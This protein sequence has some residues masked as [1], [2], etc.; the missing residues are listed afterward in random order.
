MGARSPPV[1]D[2][3]CGAS[4]NESLE[5]SDERH[6]SVAGTSV[7]LKGLSTV[8]YN[9]PSWQDP[10]PVRSDNTGQ[11][12]VALISGK[13]FSVK[14]AGLMVEDEARLDHS[15]PPLP[16]ATD[17]ALSGRIMATSG[18]SRTR[19]CGWKRRAFDAVFRVQ[20]G[21][22]RGRRTT[23]KK[24]LDARDGSG[25]LEDGGTEIP[26]QS[27]E[28]HRCAEGTKVIL[29]GLTAMQLQRSG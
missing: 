24:L 23:Y 11:D 12:S 21:K 28:T 29:K 14:L 18:I 16:R 8:Q 1:T 7:I 9:G 22:S 17:D 15:T 4:C 6:L 26:T 2:T 13:K 3:E 20:A 5:Q 25:A 10:A 19:A 27:A